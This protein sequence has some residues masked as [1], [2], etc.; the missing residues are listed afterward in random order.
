MSEGD[1]PPLVVVEKKKRTLAQKTD[2]F[3]NKVLPK[4]F[5]VFLVA[6]AFV[7]ISKLD[8]DLWAYVAMIYMGGN[9]VQHISTDISEAIKAK[10]P[11]LEE[12]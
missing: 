9:I 12:K 10:K 7:F 3:F 5:I 4:K 8:G 11:T 6:T 2:Y 1:C